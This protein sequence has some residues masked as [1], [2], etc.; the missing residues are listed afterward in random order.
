MRSCCSGSC[1]ESSAGT[2]PLC[3]HSEQ[4]NS[5]STTV[6]RVGHVV[7]V[8]AEKVALVQHLYVN[9]LNREIVSV[10][11]RVGQYLSSLRFFYFFNI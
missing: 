6:C 10:L 8:H 9:I 1:G 5:V 4:R 2:A 11:C 3:E 7:L